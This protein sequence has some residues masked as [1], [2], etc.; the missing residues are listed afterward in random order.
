MEKQPNLE[1]TASFDHQPT[2]A[3][4][5]EMCI[6]K[7]L[8]DEQTYCDELENILS[9]RGLS[10][11]SQILDVSAGGGFPALELI[12]RGYQIDSADGFADE[13]ELYNKRSL[14]RGLTSTCKE[15]MWSELPSKFE[16]G[17]YDLLLCRGNSFIYANGG[18]NQE[19]IIDPSNAIAGYTDTARIFA[20][21]LKPGGFLYIDKFTDSETTHK[22][23]VAHI[24]VK[25]EEPEDIVF[26]TE[27]LSEQKLRRA[28]MLRRQKDGSEA[29]IPNVSYDLT[30]P[31]LDV[32][33]KNAGFIEISPISLSSEK[34]FET[35][36][37]RKAV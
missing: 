13:V 3:E 17:K 2:F 23:K 19:T 12:E 29:S 27:R 14:E 5:W 21:M 16:V 35:L 31:E 20:R 6:Y 28:S 30:F 33:L 1:D 15:A 9:E 37:A 11:D 18:W 8:Y 26:W 36:L 10:K 4:L 34:I 25:N 32:I 7:F 22:E 24:Q